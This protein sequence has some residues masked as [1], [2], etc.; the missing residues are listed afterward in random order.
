M[1]VVSAETTLPG[2]RCF[3]QRTASGTVIK[4]NFATVLVENPLRRSLDERV[5]STARQ[6]QNLRVIR[7]KTN[8]R[9]GATSS[10]VLRGDVSAAMRRLL[11]RK[12]MFSGES[13]IRS[14]PIIKIAEDVTSLF[15]L[16]FVSLRKAE[17]I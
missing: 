8:D 13:F 5:N 14:H 1:P 11:C 3:R 9:V 15:P 4:N 2:F 16:H 12:K 7:Q 10:L 17:K 6:S